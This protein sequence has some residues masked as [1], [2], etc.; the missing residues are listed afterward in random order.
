MP[1]ES[2]AKKVSNKIVCYEFTGLP[3]KVRPGGTFIAEIQGDSRSPFSREG[4]GTIS[5]KSFLHNTT[6]VIPG[7]MKKEV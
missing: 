1:G 5:I 3:G 7:K 2:T 4:G 6:Q